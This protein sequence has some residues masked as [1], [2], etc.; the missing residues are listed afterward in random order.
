[1]EADALRVVNR[2]SHTRY[3]EAYGNGYSIVDHRDY[4]AKPNAPPPARVAAPPTLWSTL[5]PDSGAPIGT[6][7]SGGFQRVSTH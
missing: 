6:V 5:R 7:R 3:T 4:N 1:M 2:G